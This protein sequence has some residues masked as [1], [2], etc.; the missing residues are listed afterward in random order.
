MTL[1][2]MYSARKGCTGQAILV[3]IAIEIEIENYQK[4]IAI[5]PGESRQEALNTQASIALA[6]RKLSEYKCRGAAARFRRNP[7]LPEEKR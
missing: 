2:W 3:E 1:L 5:A 7:K 4:R 6:S